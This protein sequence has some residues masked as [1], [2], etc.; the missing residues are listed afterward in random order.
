LPVFVLPAVEGASRSAAFET[1]RG[2]RMAPSF[3][4]IEIDDFF[5]L[6]V[7]IIPIIAI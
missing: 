2:E 6:Q 5:I 3:I 1:A 4:E 7:Y